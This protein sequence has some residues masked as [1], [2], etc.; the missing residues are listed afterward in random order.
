MTLKIVTLILFLVVAVIG[1][2]YL[3]SPAVEHTDTITGEVEEKPY[4]AFALGSN[5]MLFETWKTYPEYNIGFGII[6]GIGFTGVIVSA[7]AFSKRDFNEE[8]N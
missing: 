8:I 5:N 1:L 3:L 2:K 6:S 7:M 4:V